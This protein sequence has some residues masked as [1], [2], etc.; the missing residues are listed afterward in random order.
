MW[1]RLVWWKSVGRRCGG[2]CG[3][4]LF[5]AC[6]AM[7]MRYALF[8]DLTRRRVVI[9]YANVSSIHPS[10]SPVQIYWLS[11]SL[12]ITTPCAPSHIES[13]SRRRLSFLL[14]LLTREDRTD[15]LSRNVGKQLR[16]RVISQKNAD[17]MLPSCSTSKSKTGIYLQ[18]C[19]VTQ[20]RSE[21]VAGHLEV[22]Y[23]L[24]QQKP[25]FDST[26]AGLRHVVITT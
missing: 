3:L 11:A 2:T 4:H 9:V 22:A 25:C 21:T 20:R 14:G 12:L 17:F 16:R 18:D 10:L 15:R 23:L 19:T 8:W 26:S 1:H 13:T 6:A 24:A 5:L 7:L